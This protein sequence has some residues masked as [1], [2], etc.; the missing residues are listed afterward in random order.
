[1]IIPKPHKVKLELMSDEIENL[2][3]EL[4]RVPK[5]LYDFFNYDLL[6]NKLK[7]SLIPRKVLEGCGKEFGFY[8]NDV[9]CGEEFEYD[10][11]CKVILCPECQVLAEGEKLK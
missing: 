3:E 7:N 5:N 11:E 1:M 10:G 9:T 2:I 4:N 8:G 6:I